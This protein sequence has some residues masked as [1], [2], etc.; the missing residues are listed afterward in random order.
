MTTIKPFRRDVRVHGKIPVI[1]HIP[2]SYAMMVRDGVYDR[3]RA[4]TYFSGWTCFRTK[5]FQIQTEHIPVIAIYFQDEVMSPDGDSNAGETRFRT[6]V[7]IGFS[8]IV[9]NNDPDEAE[10]DLD[11]AYQALMGGLTSDPSLM[12]NKD[13]QIQA[14]TRGMR[15]HGFGN[16][17]P[18][19]ELPFAEMRFDLTFDLGTI[20]WPPVIPDMLETIHLRTA[21]PID[22]VAEQNNVQQVNVEYDL[23]Q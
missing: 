11:I 1:G 15:T 18:T 6:S 17:G 23:D 22:D 4:M 8:A 20:T 12:N 10:K 13:F 5:A 2:R 9:Q 21:F 14:L 16:A 7:R 19:N 3:V